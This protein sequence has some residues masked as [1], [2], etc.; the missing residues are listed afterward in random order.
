MQGVA[1]LRRWRPSGLPG[2]V[3]KPVSIGR[4]L[5]KPL[6]LSV[7][8]CSRIAAQNWR[9]MRLLRSVVITRRPIV[10]LMPVQLDDKKILVRAS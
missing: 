5:G 1:V 2:N 8:I 7:V 4:R 6:L 10:G 3:A 9:C